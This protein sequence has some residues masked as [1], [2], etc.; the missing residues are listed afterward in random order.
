MSE[1]NEPIMQLHEAEPR[2]FAVHTRF[3]REKMV[4]KRLKERGLESY[5]PLQQVTRYYTRKIRRSELP[6]IASYIFVKITKKG[7]VPV[8]ED[9]DVL[10]FVRFKS[11]LIAIPEREIN[12]L[13][14]ITGEG[15]EVEVFPTQGE[16]Q[17]G[18]MVE[19]IQGRLY[20]VRGVLVEHQNNKHV[21]V[22]LDRL[23][24]SLRM[25]IEADKIR[26]IEEGIPGQ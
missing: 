13:K 16:P 14:A 8:L 23:G 21:V 12:I 18:D 4:N 3:K 25:Q 24:F 7:Y 15:V 1:P 17:P 10:Y 22:E 6:L 19:I 26:K 11:D 9:P 2:W 5:L 20:G